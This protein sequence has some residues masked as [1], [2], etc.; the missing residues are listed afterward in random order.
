MKE[1][2]ETP[3]HRVDLFQE[4]LG[5]GLERLR[6]RDMTWRHAF[7]AEGRRDGPLACWYRFLLGWV[8]VHWLPLF[9]DTQR[10]TLY[11]AMF[12]PP[13]R[14]VVE[15]HWAF[16]VLVDSLILDL[17]EAECHD[18][19]LTD[20][21]RTA[22]K[23]PKV[24]R[25]HAVQVARLFSEA[26]I[27]APQGTGAIGGGL[28]KILEGFRGSRPPQ[29]A[30]GGRHYQSCVTRFA[31]CLVFLP[32]RLFNRL[33]PHCPRVFRRDLFIRTVARDLVASSTC[34]VMF[35]ELICAFGSQRVCLDVLV[36][37]WLENL[38]Q[39]IPWQNTS[40]KVIHL[41]ASTSE[42]GDCKDGITAMSVA[43]CSFDMPP[44]ESPSA[45]RLQVMHVPPRM[46]Q[47]FL[48]ALLSIIDTRVAPGPESISKAELEVYGRALEWLLGHSLRQE[49]VVLK[50]VLI[51]RIFLR[52]PLSARLTD[53]LL[54]L[55]Q[56][57]C[58]NH[59][60]H[61][62]TLVCEVL[63]QAASAWSDEK[64]LL[65]APAKLEDHVTRVVVSG[66]RYIVRDELEDS[67]GIPGGGLLQSLLQG[68]SRRLN[69]P[70]GHLRRSGLVVA[71]CFSSVLG[72]PVAFDE[73]GHIDQSADALA[74]STSQPLQ[75][76]QARPSASLGDA[77]PRTGCTP[78]ETRCKGN[79]LDPDEVLA[80]DSDEE[81]D[82]E[83]M[84]EK[85]FDRGLQPDCPELIGPGGSVGTFPAYDL[86]DEMEDLFPMQCPLYLRTCLERAH[87]LTL[88]Y[89]ASPPLPNPTLRFV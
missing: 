24:Q 88:Y 27:T 47:P 82:R 8:A 73:L 14:G 61:R 71:Q 7:L 76:P 37:T 34:G 11:D 21:L 12:L 10:V 4:A 53:M 68:V 39:R 78:R 43:R 18:D 13:P 54:D 50:N 32:P 38:V 29:G 2:A 26:W 83:A 40:A 46:L 66:L 89:L 81:K 33:G 35:G 5:R 25:E 58:P 23:D 30:T 84:G 69:S 45:D 74:P 20:L 49:D 80:S 6:T 15:G 63:A 1:L 22:A 60:R 52:E 70:L 55:L 59:G 42:G 65:H 51:Q 19:T 41:D 48:V 86:S 62:P 3:A 56:S 87:P 64:F 36:Q 79:H 75:E 57:C 16:L 67:N 72:I 77:P 28:R 85:E 31:R 9:G 44:G 17:G